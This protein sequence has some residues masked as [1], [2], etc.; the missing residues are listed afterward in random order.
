M[1]ARHGRAMFPEVVAEAILQIPLR[2]MT[3]PDCLVWKCSRN[4][5]YTTKAGSSAWLTDV[6]SSNAISGTGA[7]DTW[8]CLW[9]LRIPP[10]VKQFMWRFLHNLLAIGTQM[11]MRSMRQ[12][13]SCPFCGLPETQAH[14]FGDCQWSS[15]CRSSDCCFD[16]FNTVKSLITIDELEKWCLLLWFL[17]KERNAQLFNGFKI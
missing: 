17:W 11:S 10:K 1:G 12:G 16:W 7:T 13:E 8:K 9:A 15:R 5:I 3:D 14:R 2:D 4:G 6:L